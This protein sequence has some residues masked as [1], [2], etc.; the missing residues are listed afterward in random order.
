M[1]GGE[2][3]WGWLLLAAGLLALLRFV[4]LGE[5][6][7]WIDEAF[8]L[9]DAYQLLD[10][11]R[12]DPRNLLGL[13]SIAA[14]LGIS[15]GWPDEL[16][17]RLAPAIFG[18]LGVFLTYWAFAPAVGRRRAA[19]AALIV[20][21]SSWHLYWSQSA[22][23]YTLAQDLSLLSAGLVLRGRLDHR[24]LPAAL[25]LAVAFVAPL[26]HLSGGW[27][28]PALVLVLLG[29]G[30]GR[31]LRILGAV[32]LAL[33]LAAAV[34]AWG[35]WSTYAESKSI[36]SPDPLHLLLTTG[37]FVTPLLCTG[38]AIGAW[39]A[40][41]RRRPFDLLVVGWIFAV[42][43]LAVAGSFVARVSAQYVFVLLPWLALLATAPLGRSSGGD[44][45]PACMAWGYLALLVL[46]QV[47][48][49]G[50]YMTVRR[51]ERPQ[52]REAYQHV[53]S[54]R[55][56]DDLVIGMA[57]PVGEYYLSPGYRQPRLSRRVLRLNRYDA[58]VPFQWA[59]QGRPMWLVIN[60]EW[61]VEFSREDRQ[62]LE[63]FLREACHLERVWPLWVEKRDLSVW[64]YRY[65]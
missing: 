51:G 41:R 31:R 55:G 4:R 48:T 11:G 3:G 39:V 2:R 54:Q 17:L 36:A 32:G 1:G 43:V 18:F 30:A 26:A 15:G 38:S 35:V 28:A 62:R 65:P 42:L 61:L 7:L 21:A 23:F 8:T 16:T 25:G 29:P 33:L 63:R 45:R 12:L 60:R 59:R 24:L 14:V 5:W 10:G 19:A 57:W 46:P 40:I 44:R 6:G 47:A 20:G 53:W 13:A 52:W 34:W 64:V 49:C 9:N 37:F 56:P 58:H 22:R 27:M 50:L